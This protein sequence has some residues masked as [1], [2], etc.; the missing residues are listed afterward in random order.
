MSVSTTAEYRP[1]AV[2][3]ATD[4]FNSAR[5]RMVRAT[6]LRTSD[7][8]PPDLTLD[9]DGRHGPPQ[10]LAVD[11]VRH[12]TERVF[13]WQ[14][15]SGLG[16]YAAELTPRRVSYLIHD[17]VDRLPDAP[18]RPQRPGDEV[19]DVGQFLFQRIP[20]TTSACL[21]EDDGSDDG[22][23]RGGEYEQPHA[24]RQQARQEPDCDR[25]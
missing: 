15:Q 12:A 19:E 24:S 13:Q 22:D 1:S 21:Q 10:V 18:S 7:R 20:A 25:Q 4:R 16:L 17:E 3:A 11:A 23:Q 5:S 9:A 2:S 14:T 8:L 6:L